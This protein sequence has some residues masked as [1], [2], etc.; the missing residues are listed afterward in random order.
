MTIC[1]IRHLAFSHSEKEQSG[2]ELRKASVHGDVFD[3]CQTERT[4]AR[5]RDGVYEIE[6][7][8]VSERCKE[9]E[10]KI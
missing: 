2:F 3:K 6:L 7:R 9:E 1:D 8:M 10:E 4:T 5:Q